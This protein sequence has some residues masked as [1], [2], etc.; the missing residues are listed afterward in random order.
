MLILSEKTVDADE[1]DNA[2]R[3]ERYH[4]FKRAN[5]YS[6]MEISQKRTALENVLIPDTLD[7]LHERLSLAGFPP[8]HDLVPVP[9]LHLA[10]R[11]QGGLRWRYSPTITACCI[12]R[13]WTKPPRMPR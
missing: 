6:D 3:V 4:D 13:F 9:E 10:D 2:W 7:A 11:F 12:K 8:L 5:G 1:R